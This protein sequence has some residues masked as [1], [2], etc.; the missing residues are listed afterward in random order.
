MRD[1]DVGIILAYFASYRK[2]GKGKPRGAS[3]YGRRSEGIIAPE[4]PSEPISKYEGCPAQCT[5][6]RCAYDRMT[7]W[8]QYKACARF[9]SMAEEPSRATQQRWKKRGVV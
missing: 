5:C 4:P 7:Y 9:R 2:P 6:Y 3:S 8:Q 1:P